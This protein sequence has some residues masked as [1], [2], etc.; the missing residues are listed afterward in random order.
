MARLGLPKDIVNRAR[1]YKSKFGSSEMENVLSDLNEQLRK[2]SERERAQKELDETRRMRGQL[3]KKRNSL[4]KTQTD[5]SE[6]SS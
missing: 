6:G 5:V 4:M 3:K 1:D 2:S